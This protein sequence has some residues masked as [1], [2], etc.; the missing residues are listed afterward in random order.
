ML[1]PP[2]VVLSPISLGEVAVLDA[3]TVD[4]G[5]QVLGTG[6]IPPCLVYVENK[7][8]ETQFVSG[9]ELRA[10][11]PR[12]L[13][14]R[15]LDALV[16]VRI[17]PGTPGYPGGGRSPLTAY[18]EPTPE[19]LSLSPDAIDLDPS[20][21]VRVT[22][23]GK[24][25]LYGSRAIFLG[26]SFPLT[27]TRP[28]EGTVELPPRVLGSPSEEHRLYL[29]VPWPYRSPLN[30]LTTNALRLPVRT[31]T[32]TIAGIWP[33]TLNA[34]DMLQGKAGS[35]RSF[36]IEV[37]GTK[38]RANTV[39]KWNGRPLQTYS[40]ASAGRIRADLPRDARAE[41]TTIQVS[42]ETPSTQGPLV[43]GNYPLA[44]KTPPVVY[45]VSPAWVTVSDTGVT[46]ELRGEGLGEYRQQ[47]LL[48]NGT[49]L[50]SESFNENPGGPPYDRWT[51][52]VPPQWLAQPGVFPVTVRRTYDGAESAPLF[53][54][55]VTESPAPLVQWL[56]PSVL[57]VGDAP[58]AISISGAAFTSQTIALVNGQER[59]TRIESSGYLTTDLLSSDLER[60]GPLS[61]TVRT[62]PPGGGT[63]L[64]LLL[65]VHAERTTPIIEA[66]T[67]PAGENPLMARD[68]PMTLHVQGQG[69]TPGSVVRWKG[70]P[71]PTQ[72]QCLDNPCKAG[73][74]TKSELTAVIPAEH[75]RTPGPAK[76]TVFTPGPGGGESRAR[77]LVITSELETRLSLNLREM[78][79]RAVEEGAATRVYFTA[80]GLNGAQVSKLLVNGLERPFNGVD[81]SFLLSPQEAATDGVLE[82]RVL[83]QGRGLSAPTHLYVNGARTPRIREL[84]PGVLSQDP[85]G[86]EVFPQT[87]MVA[88]QDFLWTDEPTRV[89]RLM[90]SVRTPSEEA[91][92]PG[93]RMA[94]SQLSL[95]VPGIRTVTLSRVAEGGG[96]SLPALLN[97]V[98]ERAAPLLT[99][100]EPMFVTAGVPHLRVRIWAQGLHTDSQLRWKDF[101]S[102]IKPVHFYSSDA[103]N[104]EAELPAAALATPGMVDVTIETPAP[105]GGTSLPIRVVVE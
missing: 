95:D 74:G 59:P 62:P 33:P 24:N 96:L 29:E 84:A 2:S 105:G 69:F 82:I 21:P 48:W 68:D 15:P 93:D 98:P 14:W 35:A 51:F 61:I 30:P 5:I 104:Y 60:K 9:T 94:F 57:S 34:V 79:V 75:A 58:G 86:R 11:L 36:S 101:R 77:Y 92:T 4:M 25:L 17:P 102:R 65:A 76:V 12:T 1:P 73:P 72:W 71:M 55:V 46:F 67:G 8:L 50:P 44:V 31:P 13:L 20:E 19:L 7:A 70:L 10:R 99:K 39:V 3:V 88:G 18:L 27:V 42:L 100:L 22:V 64:P 32:P 63:S 54:Q 49:P 43:S 16:E 45:A 91:S 97:V 103:N 52:R 41:A 40:S 56:N 26:E 6:F 83:V 90:M 85:L 78:N 81:G 28:T 38:L 89:S 87:F 80:H 37:S 66:V 47:V 53:V 23:K